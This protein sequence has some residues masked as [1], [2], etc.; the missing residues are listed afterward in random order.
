MYGLSS[1]FDVLVFYRPDLEPAMPKGAV[2]HAI[3]MIRMQ[4]L[5]GI[6]RAKSKTIFLDFA[7]IIPLLAVFCKLHECAYLDCITE[8]NRLCRDG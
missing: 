5:S 4:A 1:G 2:N 6:M 8:T 3:S 7:R